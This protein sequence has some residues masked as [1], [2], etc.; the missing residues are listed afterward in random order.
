MSTVLII[1][2]LVVWKKYDNEWS[3]ASDAEEVE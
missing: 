2:G 1:D 3:F